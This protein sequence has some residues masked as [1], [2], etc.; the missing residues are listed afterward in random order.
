MAIRCWWDTDS[1]ERY[2]MEI[3]ERD[4][5]GADLHA[6]KSDGSGREYWSYSLVNEVDDGDVVLHWWTRGDAEPAL[7]GWSR[8]IG[9][10]RSSQITWQARG[11]VGRARGV[12][13]VGPAWRLPL[14]GFT[15]FSPSIGLSDLRALESELKQVHDDLVARHGGPLYFPFA[16]R[17]GV[18]FARPRVTW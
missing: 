17:I 5:I 14:T 16:F 11:T 18:P 9:P 12:P 10:V 8:A 7:V 1:S 15:E 13:T 2:W 6:P 3:T 4:D